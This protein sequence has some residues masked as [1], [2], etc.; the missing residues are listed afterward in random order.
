V[1][2]VSAQNLVMRAAV[3]EED[4]NKVR[5]GQVVRMTLYSFPG[6]VF[7]GAVSKIYDK[8]DPERR[9]F[10][11]D[12]KLGKPDQRFSPGMTGE[13]AFIMGEK[14]RA[15]IVPAQAWQEGAL[16]VVKDDKLSR[17]EAQ[18]GLR[19]IERIEVLSGLDPKA[20]V[21][22]SPVG[23]MEEGQR[24]RVERIDPIVAAGLNKPKEKGNFKGFN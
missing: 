1:A 24:V 19:S 4:K 9:T 16:W 20:E 15:T 3:D 21:V 17:A 12:V 13:L 8:A 22:I 5:P 6:E 14:D 23:K 11:I 7:E 10:E 18:I 2:D